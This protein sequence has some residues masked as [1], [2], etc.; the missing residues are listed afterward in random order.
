MHVPPAGWFARSRHKRWGEIFFLA[1]SPCWIGFFA[2]IV[3]TG[4]YETFAHAE[5]MIVCLTIAVPCVLLP[6]VL[7]PRAE[8]ALPL[9]YRYWVKANIWI[10]I[11][12]FVG[13]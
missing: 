7:Q 8:S 13:K 10:F 6:L 11:I 12:S 3:A 2:A 4:V 1:Y 5:Y 9:M